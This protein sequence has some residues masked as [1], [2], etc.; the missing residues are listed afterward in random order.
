MPRSRTQRRAKISP[1]IRR[2]T[3]IPARQHGAISQ[4]AP[5]TIGGNHVR[6]AGPVTVRFRKVFTAIS[7]PP[8]HSPG[9]SVRQ[10]EEV[11][12]RRLPPKKKSS[13]G[14][15]R[16]KV[17]APPHTPSTLHTEHPDHPGPELPTNNHP[18]PTPAQTSVEKA[19]PTTR[20]PTKPHQDL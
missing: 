20:P 14:P 3:F 11:P 1:E 6:R 5:R 4:T 16:A 10:Q 18:D 13:P 8:K 9:Q 2:R 15:L 12:P 7:T 17:T 19:P